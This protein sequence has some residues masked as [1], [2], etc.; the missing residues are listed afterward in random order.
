VRCDTPY[1]T[2]NTIDVFFNTG[3]IEGI[4]WCA[5]YTTGQEPDSTAANQYSFEDDP[6][7][8]IKSRNSAVIDVKDA[9]TDHV[10]T[11]SS[12]QADTPYA[13][14]CHMDDVTMSAELNVWTAPNTNIWGD[15]LVR[16][17]VN[18]ADTS[19]TLTLT[20]TH[21]A[22]LGNAF[23]IVL[24]TTENIFSATSGNPTCSATKDGS[25]F[26]LHAT[27]ATATD[28]SSKKVITFTTHASTG[29]STAGSEI[30]ITCTTLLENPASA[31]T[32]N[33]I[34]YTLDVTGHNIRNK[35]KGPK[36]E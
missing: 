13:I 27:A 15:S 7:T 20:F 21:G 2:E 10:I 23:V 19:G 16:S 30:I 24:T 29:G 34:T 31:P 32:V 1:Y 8:D 3:G 33:P 11:L 9:K 17:N 4:A 6:D 26:A 36:F 28:L 18:F 12:L 25:A 14:Y 22:T 35:R 5:A